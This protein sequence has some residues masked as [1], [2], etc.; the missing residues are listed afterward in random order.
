VLLKVIAAVY[1]EYSCGSA[2]GIATGYEMGDPEVEVLVPVGFK[3]V[4]FS[5]SSVPAVGS[6][7]PPIQFVPGALFP[8]GGEINPEECGA[9]HPPPASAEVKILIYTCT[10]TYVFMA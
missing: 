1:C 2:V 6:T 9:D 5:I 8:G 7:Q 4:H 3:N 10:L